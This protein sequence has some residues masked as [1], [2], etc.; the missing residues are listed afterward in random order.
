MPERDLVGYYKTIEDLFVRLRGAP[1]IVSPKDY[2]LMRQWWDQGVPLAAVL[3]GV[4]EVFERRRERGEDPVSSLTYCR[5]AVAKHARRLAATVMEAH[6]VHPVDVPLGLQRS[7]AEVRGV[8]RQWSGEPAVAEALEAVATAIDSLPTE[9]A[10]AAIDETL[11]R[12]EQAALDTVGV[13]LPERIR[14][15]IETAVQ[16][17]MAGVTGD[18]RTL[19][20]MRKALLAKERRRAIGL[21]RLSLPAVE[22]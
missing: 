10:P 19:A 13:L 7:A 5:H 3:A 8:A 21:G 14:V 9:A 4:S 22:E 11:G 16:E 2:G 20:R 6:Q 1:F 18:G 17:S 12:L 15:A